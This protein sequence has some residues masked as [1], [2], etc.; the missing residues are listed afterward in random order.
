MQRERRKVEQALP[1]GQKYEV[2]DK[3]TNHPYNSQSPALGKESLQIN[4]QGV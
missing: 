2:T 4:V 3:E 1:C